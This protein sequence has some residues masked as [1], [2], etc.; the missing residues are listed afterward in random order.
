M[1]AT[2]DIKIGSGDLSSD[3]PG[4]LVFT[5][6]TD[7]YGIDM[8]NVQELCSRRDMKLAT[9]GPQFVTGSMKLHG[10]DVPIVDMRLLLDIT[11][12]DEEDSS[13]I[14]VLNMDGRQVGIL[15][16]SVSDTAMLTPHKVQS[17]STI[18]LLQRCL[19]YLQ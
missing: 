7:E 14:I 13:S 17:M 11:A 15:V 18:G 9:V 1:N 16:D 19:S 5:V 4:F 3:P 2:T 10:L 8:R 6:G 12:H